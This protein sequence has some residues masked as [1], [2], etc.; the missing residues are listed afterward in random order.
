MKDERSDA[1]GFRLA[2]YSVL[3][4]VHC[5]LPTAHCLLPTAY[6]PLPTAYCP[7]PTAYCLLPTIVCKHS[8]HVSVW[9][10][11][12]TLIRKPSPQPA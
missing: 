12:P 11:V 3:S 4:T 9:A 1:L 5:P 2:A 7:L 8:K 10:S 6:C